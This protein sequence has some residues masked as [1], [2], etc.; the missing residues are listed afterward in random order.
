MQTKRRS[1]AQI[2]EDCTVYDKPV[3]LQRQI[4]D[5]GLW[6]DVQHLHCAVN[7]AVSPQ[8]F[9]AEAERLRTR[10]TFRVRY[11]AAL[12]AVRTAPQQYRLCY[13][14][15][16]YEITDYDDYEERRRVIRLTG[17]RY[18]L[19]VTV[20]LLN[21]VFTTSH[22]VCRKIYPESGPE[23]SC[24]W[25]TMPSAESKVNGVVSVIDQARITVRMRPEI[26]ADCRIQ[27][28]DGTLWEIIG[29][30]ENTGLSDRWAVFTV[31]RIGGG[32]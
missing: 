7:K 12:D 21:P 20:L 32:A 5:S 29:T 13:L 2:R 4:P 1:A 26:T 3:T 23:I 31:R 9:D 14:G 18:E 25:V 15:S 27:R 11:F 24:C 19:P 16:H 28:A 30:P 10:L 17:E 6:E 22:G 8:G